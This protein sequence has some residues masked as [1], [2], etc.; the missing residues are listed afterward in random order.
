M[1]II[2]S[3]NEEATIG[4]VIDAIRE[5]LHR[6]N[7]LV[8]DGY[9]SDRTVGV[10]LAHG[11]SVIQV[12]KGFGIGA[13]VEAGILHAYGKGYRYLVRVD[14]DGQHPASELRKV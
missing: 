6:C 1:V 9:S 13:P 3:L 8:I 14:A 10:A 4:G 2:P 5:A 12:D 11:G 7:V